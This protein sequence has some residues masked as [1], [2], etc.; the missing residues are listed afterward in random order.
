MSMGD[1]IPVSVFRLQEVATRCLWWPPLH[2]KHR[3]ET[4]HSGA[5]KAHDWAVEQPADLFRTTHKVKTQQ[6]TE[7]RRQHCG[8]IHLD[9]CL[10]N[11]VGPVPLVLDLR[12]THERWGS[13]SDPNLNGHLHF[14]NEIDRSLNETG[15][16]KIRRKVSLLSGGSWCRILKVSILIIRSDYNNN[17]PHAISF[18]SGIASTSGRLHCDLI[19]LLFLQA[20]RETDCFFAAS[21]VQLA[22]STSGGFFHFRRT[23]FFSQHKAKMWKAAA[24]RINLNLDGVSITSK[25]HTHPSHSQTS[26]LLTSFFK[27]IFRCSSSTTTRCMCAV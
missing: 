25:S 16:T 4:V 11:A 10:T 3:V 8:D 1:Q 2:H 9:A 22:Q 17:P 23:V 26:R 27:F 6:V 24:L 20:Y 21:G 19:R 13:R 18:M 12:I 14:P 15:D 5:K 7:N